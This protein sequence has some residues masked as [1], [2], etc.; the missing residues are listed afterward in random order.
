M[1]LRTLHVAAALSA[2]TC[3]LA[4]AG[5]VSGHVVDD[6]G[7][8]VANALLEFKR[9]KGGG[10]TVVVTGGFTDANGAFS[11]TVTP[12][13]NYKMTVYPA[14][15]PQSLVVVQQFSD[16]AIGNSTN[17][18]G[19][20]T[21]FVGAELKGRTV[22]V[23]GTPLVNVSMEFVVGA[24]QPLNFTNK[25]T[26]IFGRFDVAIPFGQSHMH[27][28]P[29]A[30]PYY[31]GNQS[32]PDD[33][34][35]DVQQSEDIGDITMPNGFPLTAFVVDASNNVGIP[36]VQVDLIDSATGQIKFLP[37]NT[38]DSYG[39]LSSL[40]VAGTYDFR[41][42]PQSG[43]PFVPS[44]YLHQTMLGAAS[45]GVVKLQPG[46]QLSG[47]VIGADNLAKAGVRIGLVDPTT[48]AP[49]YLGDVQTSASG[50]YSAL[51]PNGTFDVSMSP[52]FSIPFGL[53]TNHGVVIAGDT[54]S[55]G[56]LPSLPFFSIVGSGTQGAGGFTPAISATGG[57]PRIGNASYS[58]HCAQAVGG[59]KALVVYSIG[60]PSG[61]SHPFSAATPTV[62]KFVQLGGASG[63]AGVGVGDF[64]MPIANDA[65]LAGSLLRARFFVIDPAGAGGHAS[66]PEL[67]ATINL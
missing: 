61:G 15:P 41:F 17:N 66:T 42:T 38:T 55:N 54:T 36:N 24:N 48:H 49:I 30:P 53:G 59:A 22:N 34:E 11:A 46:V 56:T 65:Q 45:L 12:N 43:D 4:R 67:N 62:R 29:G 35:L 31:G 20:L 51:A 1:F 2:L 28:T 5:V 58:L 13:D 9:T 64:A 57:T 44:E 7:H 25:D 18:V 39:M 40:L 26:D 23:A 52:P 14:P 6:H 32:G 63:T 37:D 3:G 10:K 50:N 16:I 19:T 21:M 8:P 47:K 27:F 60:T 33:L